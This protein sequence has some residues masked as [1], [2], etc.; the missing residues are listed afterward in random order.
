MV[1]R[2]P[3]LLPIPGGVGGCVGHHLDT[4]A[5]RPPKM[6]SILHFQKKKISGVLPF[7]KINHFP[8]III[9]LW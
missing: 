6:F 9:Y 5:P 1:E 7:M 4:W 3:D 2:K 8:K